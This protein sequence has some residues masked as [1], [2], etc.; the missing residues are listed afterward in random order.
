[1]HQFNNIIGNKLHPTEKPTELL[2]FYIN[3]SSNVGD[4][5][6][7][8]FAGS[9]STLLAAKELDRKYIGYEIDEIYYKI[10]DDRLQ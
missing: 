4:L 3:N 10:A 9:G 6:C 7:D 1:M 2:K 5:I 8:P